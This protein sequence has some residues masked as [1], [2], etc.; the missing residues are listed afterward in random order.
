MR[1]VVRFALSE[2]HD[3]FGRSW[4]FVDRL[5]IVGTLYFYIV[6]LEGNA[7]SLPQYQC[8]RAEM[9]EHFPPVDY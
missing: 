7:P 6:K 2:W 5:L 1:A 8:Q 9:T 4:R 3:A